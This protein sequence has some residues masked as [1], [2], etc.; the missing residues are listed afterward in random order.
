MDQHFLRTGNCQIG[1]QHVVNAALHGR[2]S[3]EPARCKLFPILVKL[4]FETTAR[5]RALR[6]VEPIAEP[7]RV[8]IQARWSRL[9]Q[10]R[11]IA[12][13]RNVPAVASLRC[14][15]NRNSI[16]REP[17]TGRARDNI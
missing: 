2:R 16:D 13:V 9:L 7:S 17:G 10:L 4:E 11:A 12:I 3:R 14:H 15:Y 5:A 1:N 6:P 8:T